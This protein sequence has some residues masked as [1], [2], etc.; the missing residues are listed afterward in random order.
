MFGFLVDDYY[1]G[2]F[3]NRVTT[4]V[5]ITAVLAVAQTM[6]VVTRNIDLSVGSIV[7]VSAYLTGE[8]AA[9]HQ[10]ASP[11]LAIALALGIGALLGAV[12][13]LMVAYG[14]VPAI[15]VTLGTLAI[16][17]SWLVSHAE[18]RTITAD[19]LPSWVVDLPTRTVVSVGG[20]DVRAVFAVVV[21]IVVLLAVAMQRLRWGR[22]LY[23]VGSNPEAATQAG[24]P[25]RRLVF[26]A[27][28]ACGALS[29]LAGFLFLARF[30]TITVVAGPGPGAGLGGRGGGRRGERARRVRDAGRGVA[31]RGPHRRARPEPGA[32]PPGQRVLAQRHPRGADPRRRGCRRGHRPAV[33]AALV[34]R[35]PAPHK[36]ATSPA[37]QP[38]ARAGGQRCAGGETGADLGAAAGRHPRGDDR[39]QRHPLAG[40]PRRR[41]LREP[42]PAVDREGDRRRD[43]DLRHHQRRDRPVGGLGDGL[44]GLRARPPPTRRACPSPWPSCS[45]WRRRPPPASCRARW[46]PAPAS[47]RWWSPW[48]GSSA[49]RGAARILLEDR[50]VGDFPDWFGDLGR[51]D[52][53]ARCRSRWCCSWS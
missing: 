20:L 22:R 30:G 12:N 49:S 35:G 2:R 45:P 21:V 10:D 8:Y 24:L 13:G 14:R 33:P 38:A 50:S 6:V 43:H 41:Q 19:S 34:G 29:G 53:W 3:F 37:I 52:L 42:V 51:D 11:V 9:A 39:L 36:R 25:T 16:Y 46:S 26:G 15:I 5:A 18:A 28:V 1:S 44:L 27:F 48:P 40:L 4:S 17:R 47:R 32:G 23:A 7:G 31:G